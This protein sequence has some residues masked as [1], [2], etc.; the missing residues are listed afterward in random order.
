MGIAPEHSPSTYDAPNLWS[1]LDSHLLGATA[2]V[3][4]FKA[5]SKSW[6]GTSHE[7]VF[8]HLAREIDAE[9]TELQELIRALGHEPSKPKLLIGGIGAGIATLNPLNVS[10]RR[11]NAG[12]QLELEALQSMLRGKEALW[13]TLLALLDSPGAPAPLNRGRIE[14]LLAHARAQQCSVADVMVATA[15]A[16][17]LRC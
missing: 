6:A 3:R 16:R 4:A 14:D 17:F 12:S 10:R 1:Y 7:Q 2:G 15:S 5:A 9:R 13:Q 11:R 8:V